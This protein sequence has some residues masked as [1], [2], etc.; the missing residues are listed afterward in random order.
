MLTIRIGKV[1]SGGQ[2]GADRGGLDAAIESGTP[3]GGWCPKGRLAE[4]GCIP[5]RYRLRETTTSEYA[6]RTELNVRDSDATLVFTHGPA[7]GGSLQT[8]E[9]AIRWGRPWLHVDIAQMTAAK[10]AKSICQ[11][12]NGIWPICPTRSRPRRIILNVAGSRASACPKMHRFVK[13]VVL[14]V[15]NRINEA[16]SSAK[17][18]RRLTL[19]KKAT[20]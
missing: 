9:F 15:I 17:Q 18:R 7:T 20:E 2:T 1:V 4:D 19:K 5:S 6:E 14:K 16:P 8:I 3:H 12:L 13:A 10:A 11:W